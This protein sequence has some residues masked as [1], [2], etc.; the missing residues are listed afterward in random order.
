MNSTI[1]VNVNFARNAMSE[2]IDGLCVNDMH[3]DSE[4]LSTLSDCIEQVERADMHSIVYINVYG[5]SSE[6]SDAASEDAACFFKVET[7]KG[8]NYHSCELTLYVR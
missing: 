8:H 5:S 1:S 4:L 3:M 6:I 7:H 2:M